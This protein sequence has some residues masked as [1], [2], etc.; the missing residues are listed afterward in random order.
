MGQRKGVDR[1][2]A[3]A[4]TLSF[5]KVIVPASL[6]F[7][8]TATW[9]NIPIPSGF[10][11]L[12]P[13]WL[14]YTTMGAIFLGIV[15][16]EAVAAHFIA[17]LPWKESFRLC[18]V[19]NLASS[20]FG[21]FL[22][23]SAGIVILILS[24]VV[25]FLFRNEVGPQ[26]RRFLRPACI[27]LVIGVISQILL[28]RVAVEDLPLAVYGSLIPAFV[29][30]ILIE[31]VWWR[32][33]VDKRPALLGTLTA[34]ALSYSLLVGVILIAGISANE[35]P[36]ASY[37]FYAFQAIAAA[38]GGKPDEAMKRLA[39][40]RN[41]AMTPGVGFW[42]RRGGDSS[43]GRVHPYYPRA[44][45]RVAEVLMSAGQEEMAE[46]ILT[47]VLGLPDVMEDEIDELRQMLKV[48]QSR[49][50]ESSEAIPEE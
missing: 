8:A 37:T 39:K 40:A 26:T 6:L 20:L 22:S 43:E 19:A 32:R 46:S 49:N 24:L 4:S 1:P 18:L 27:G 25:L 42:F 31:V 45:K 44:E 33:A 13:F 35:T 48:C 50:A 2:G 11:F 5:L 9:A 34:N 36:L 16:L 12:A 47:D 21:A 10:G 14:S 23:L 38:E 7:Q 17:R 28:Y 3:G 15:L 30:T 29:I 41:V